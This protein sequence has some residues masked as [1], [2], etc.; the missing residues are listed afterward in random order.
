MRKN[1]SLRGGKWDRIS[2]NVEGKKSLSQPTKKMSKSTLSPRGRICESRRL[3]QGGEAYLFCQE[4]QTKNS[5]FWRQG[6]QKMKKFTAP[7]EREHLHGKRKKESYFFTRLIILE[8]R[9]KEGPHFNEWGEASVETL[10]TPR[11]LGAFYAAVKKSMIK[12]DKT[13]GWGERWGAT[14]H[15]RLGAKRKKEDDY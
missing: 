14:P 13:D 3:R 8:D 1:L 6:H 9:K 5:P 15:E 2:I 10:A 7:L 11:R 4:I 12:S